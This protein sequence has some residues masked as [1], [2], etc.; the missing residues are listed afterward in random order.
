M[1]ASGAV[2]IQIT[3]H[4]VEK[5]GVDPAFRARL[6][7]EP[8]AVL[9]DEFGLALPDAISVVMTRSHCGSMPEKSWAAHSGTDRFSA[10]EV[11]S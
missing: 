10:G 7:E 2:R 5:A 3:N 11:S 6:L 9:Q 1:T 8:K 4:L